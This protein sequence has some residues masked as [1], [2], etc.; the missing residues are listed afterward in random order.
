ML[1]SPILL[2]LYPSIDINMLGIAMVSSVLIDVDHL[3][4][5]IHERAFSYTKIKKVYDDIY[6]NYEADPT[7]AY[8]GVVY[9]FHTVEFNI[10]LILFSLLY[11]FLIFVA[12]GFVFHIICDVIDCKINKR[13]IL[14][15]L[16]LYKS[17][18]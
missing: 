15:W 4:L 2:L 8:R 10:L 6:K 16:F 9:L 12:L 17:I 18:N 1:V 13:P 5:L 11:P 7:G 3:E 14:R